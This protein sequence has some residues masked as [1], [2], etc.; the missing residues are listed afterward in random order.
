MKLMNKAEASEFLSKQGVEPDKKVKE[1]LSGF[2]LSR[3]MYE[4]FFSPGD[5]LY[6]FVRLPSVGSPVFERGCWFGLSGVSLG[7]AA[8]FGGLAGR[9]LQ[10]FKV[11]HPFSA[12]EGTAAPFPIDWQLEIGGRG[13]MTQVFVPRKYAGLIRSLGSAQT[14]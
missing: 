7:G 12:L 2:D 14:A 4:H 8:I 9:T 11:I 13:G 1:V 10:R 6:Q 5:E 3:P